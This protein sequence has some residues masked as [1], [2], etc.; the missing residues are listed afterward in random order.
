[1][2]T[3]TCEWCGEYIPA[4]NL[5]WPGYCSALHRDADHNRRQAARDKRR[6]RSARP[7]RH[8]DDAA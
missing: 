4:S 7:N 8:D 3:A 5:R 6:Q 1:M 2:S